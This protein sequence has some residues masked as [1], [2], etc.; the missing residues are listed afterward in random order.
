[1]YRFFKNAVIFVIDYS[2]QGGSMSEKK[3]TKSTIQLKVKEIL[4]NSWKSFRMKY[5][6]NVLIVFIVG[7]IVG[8]YSL[9]TSNATIGSVRTADEIQMQAV[10]DRATGKS[11]A[12]VLEDLVNGL[13]FLHIDTSQANTTAQK[14]TRGVISVFVNQISSSGSV[15]F[16]I[17]NGINTLVFNNSIGRSIVIFLLVV[18]LFLVNVF[19]RYIFI[20][21]K[22]RY[23]LEH[24]KYSETKIDRLLFVYKHGQTKNVAKVMLIK[25]FFQL[26]WN[27]TIIGGVI[28]A[29]EYSMIPYILAENPSIEW[30]DAFRLSKE[31]TRGEKRRIFLVDLAYALGYLASSFTYNFLAV[32]LF[33]PLKECAYA[34]IYMQLREMKASEEEKYVLL[35]D[36]MLAVANISKGV[37]PES[38]YMIKP[39]EKRQWLKIDYDRK[40]T[41]STIVLF[42]F[43]FSFVGWAWEVFYTL[44]NEGILANRGTLFGPWLPIYGVGGMIIIVFLKPLRKNPLVM[45]IGAFVACGALEYFTSWML[46]VLF[47]SK[48]W[49]YTGY[50]LNINGRICLEGLFVFGLAGVAFTYVFAPLLDNLYSKLKPNMRKPICIVLLSFFVVDLVWSAFHPNMGAGVTYTEED[51]DTLTSASEVSEIE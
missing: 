25:Y 4:K 46:E 42:F 45:F 31:L 34:E 16:G 26:F 3:K 32:F 8:G 5:F 44:L 6:T 51:I 7:V 23:F 27:F 43:S 29:Y 50:F 12:E 49:D 37:Y 22:N 1:M 36:R 28:K 35:N 10:Y 14:Y 48:W 13:E 17:L 40:Y 15:G 41:F 47:D 2:N 30:K 33:N 20:V 19:V 38:A 9:T 21:G 24:R 39:L 11:N 18:I